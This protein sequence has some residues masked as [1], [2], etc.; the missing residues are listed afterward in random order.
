MYRGL[1]DGSTYRL[2]V[3]AVNA[4]GSGRAARAHLRLRAWFRDPLHDKR[5]DQI[6]VPTD[7]AVRIAPG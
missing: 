6:A 7:P 1:L 5:A 2:A 3:R 4:I